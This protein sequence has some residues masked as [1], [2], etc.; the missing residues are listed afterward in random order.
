MVGSGGG[1]GRP[2]FGVRLWAEVGQRQRDGSNVV[3]PQ[4]DLQGA[5]VLK[6]LIRQRL[7]RPLDLLNARRERTQ[8]TS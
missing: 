7:A 3:D 5:D 2:L 8:P 1:R 4:Q 6:T